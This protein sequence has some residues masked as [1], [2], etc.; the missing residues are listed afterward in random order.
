MDESC[1]TTYS[2][3][4]WR[5]ANDKEIGEKLRGAMRKAEVFCRNFSYIGGAS[6][7]NEALGESDRCLTDGSFMKVSRSCALLL[8]CISARFHRT[9]A[10]LAKKLGGGLCKEALDRTLPIVR[11]REQSNYKLLQM[12]GRASDFSVGKKARQSVPEK[13][14]ITPICRL[15][16]PF[17]MLRISDA[18]QRRRFR[19]RCI[20]AVS[21]RLTPSRWP[22][23]SP[24]LCE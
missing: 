17:R 22:G 21:K 10:I 16:V 6:G 15:T 23:V 13:L 12:H 5:R 11:T 4:L 24:S 14:P 3:A 19:L 18:R 8:D 20:D 7:P 9:L 1:G 2:P